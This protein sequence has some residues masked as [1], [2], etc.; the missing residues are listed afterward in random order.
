[1]R[2]R[3]VE[4]AEA[5][6]DPDLR[7]DDV[8]ERRTAQSKNNVTPMKIGVQTCLQQGTFQPWPRVP[9]STNPM[10]GLD[11]DIQGAR[12]PRSGKLPRMAEFWGRQNPL[13]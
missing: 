5:R 13:Q 7:R 9:S 3:F 11:P 6:V 1:M 8:E 10:A 4:P 2:F 12:P